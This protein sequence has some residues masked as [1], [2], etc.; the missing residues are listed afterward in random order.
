MAHTAFGV[1]QDSAQPHARQFP[2]TAIAWFGL[3]LVLC[4]LPVLIPLVNQW[5]NDED[6][7]HGFF[8]PVLAGYIAWRERDAL[9]AAPVSRN[10][11]GFALLAWAALQLT[12][13]TLGAELFLAR[14]AF[15]LSIV[16]AVWFLAGTRVLRVAAFPLFLLFFMV[17]LPSIVYNQI[18]FPLQ[19]LASSVAETVLGSVGIPV[20]REGNVLELA[21]QKLSVV[22]ACSGIRSLLS[23][24][25]LALIY[26]YFSDR[27]PWMKWVLLVATVPIA[28]I[29]NATRVTLTGLFSE[30]NPDL[31]HGFFH[32]AQG[33]VI[34]M[35]A[36][37]LLV[38]FHT[39]VNG[40][41]KLARRGHAETV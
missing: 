10:W 24:S 7:G 22:E 16:G 26:S 4:Y 17:P 8:V 36:L 2:W 6:M 35:A 25:F 32:T 20:L 3:L 21:S 37:I 5:S 39:L 31:A 30:Y 41:Y 27:K 38:A 29:A 23:L 12:I 11:F 14:T 40:M 1:S 18:T 28:I 34:F 9:L 19:L 13:A 15:V 33:W